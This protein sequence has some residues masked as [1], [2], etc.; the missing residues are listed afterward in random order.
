MFPYTGLRERDPTY[1][2]Q[3]G[4]VVAETHRKGPDYSA[5]AAIF[6]DDVSDKEESDEEESE[7]E[8]SDKKVAIL[9]QVSAP[10]VRGVD[11]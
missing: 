1:T 6:K 5:D 7:E 4:C 2:I 10:P 9:I 8:E 11:K 3:I